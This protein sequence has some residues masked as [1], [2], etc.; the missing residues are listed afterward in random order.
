MVTKF[1]HPLFFLWL[2]INSFEKKYLKRGFCIEF[3]E[4]PLSH[5]SSRESLPKL[6]TGKPNLD[7]HQCSCGERLFYPKRH[8]K[9]NYHMLFK[10]NHFSRF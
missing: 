5:F 3:E 9:E 1:G 8:L 7:F 2:T 10:E 4:N 6:K